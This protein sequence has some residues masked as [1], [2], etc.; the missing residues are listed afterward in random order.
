MDNGIM[1]L[2]YDLIAI[3]QNTIEFVLALVNG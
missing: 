1:V 2:I 3:L